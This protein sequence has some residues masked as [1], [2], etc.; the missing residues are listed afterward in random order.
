MRFKDGSDVK[1]DIQPIYDGDG[2]RPEAFG[3]SYTIDGVR[4][5]KFFENA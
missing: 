3:V 2:I 4:T 5:D 1:V